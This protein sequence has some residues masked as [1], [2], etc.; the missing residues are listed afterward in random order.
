MIRAGK[1]FSEQKIARANQLSLE[2]EIK[3][4][5]DEITRLN[6]ENKNL[7]Q[8]L[9]L[10]KIQRPEKPTFNE[11]EYKDANLT[12]TFA[13]NEVREHNKELTILVERL[14]STGGPK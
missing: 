6:T 1:S 8:R 12:L 11:R 2:K 14:L 9:F 5:N 4:L 13:L 10:S 3:R 7:T